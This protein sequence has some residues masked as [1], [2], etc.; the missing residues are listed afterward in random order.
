MCGTHY[1]NYMTCAT[2]CQAYMKL[3]VVELERKLDTVEHKD[4]GESLMGRVAALLACNKLA[5]EGVE[6]VTRCSSS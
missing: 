1:T 5:I 3:V 4:W 6:F 2:V